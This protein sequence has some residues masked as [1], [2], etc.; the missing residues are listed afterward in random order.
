MTYQK[1]GTGFTELL[2][3]NPFYKY[4]EEVISRWF[5]LGLWFM[6]QYHFMPNYIIGKQDEWKDWVGVSLNGW[7][8]NNFSICKS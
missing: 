1:I 5:D 6:L 4:Q 2:A 8:P 7:K 3:S